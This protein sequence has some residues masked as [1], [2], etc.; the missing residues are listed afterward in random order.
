MEEIAEGFVAVANE[1]MCRPIRNLTQ[2]RGYD[3]SNHV[4]SC[5]GGAG[6][7][8]AC[9]VARSLGIKQVFIH[10]HASI[11]SAY[12][13]ALASVVEDET[14]PFGYAFEASS[15]EAISNKIDDLMEKFSKK[16]QASGFRKEEITFT[17]FLNI[18]YDRTDCAIMCH[19]EDTTTPH[20]GMKHGNFVDAFTKQYRR[21]FGFIIPNR[22]MIVDDVRVRADARAATV[23]EQEIPQ[24]KDDPREEKVQ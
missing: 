20:E 8:H 17:P 7:Q 12:G 13:M 4:L 21:E 6:G 5:F 16:L 23:H 19:P 22:K 15:H 1:A 3:P 11:L 24:A 14:S 2:A 9:D 10:K 18:R